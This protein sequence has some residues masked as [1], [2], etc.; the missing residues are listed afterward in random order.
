MR[1]EELMPGDVRSL[2]K[3]QPLIAVFCVI[4]IMVDCIG[5]F[6]MEWPSSFS[7]FQWQLLVASC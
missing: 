5:S 7:R 2:T 6:Q 3:A 4:H 1:R